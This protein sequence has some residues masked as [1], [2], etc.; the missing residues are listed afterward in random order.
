MKKRILIK[1]NNLNDLFNVS[2]Y[3]DI[4]NN[5]NNDIGRLLRKELLTIKEKKII[6]IGIKND[7]YPLVEKEYQLTRLV[8]EILREFNHLVLIYTTNDLILRDLD[9]LTKINNNSYVVIIFANTLTNNL[10]AINIIAKT[11]IKVGVIIK[12]AIDNKEDI[13]DI[14]KGVS[15]S[16]AD[17]IVPL[18]DI[19]FKDTKIK[20]YFYKIAKEYNIDTKIPAFITKKICNQLDIFDII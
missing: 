11:N 14:I 19:N 6:G 17:F 13:K 1:N 2:Y 4:Y 18:F 8:L 16:G 3:I 7:A 12:L 20:E 10:N 9:L 15:E 5:I